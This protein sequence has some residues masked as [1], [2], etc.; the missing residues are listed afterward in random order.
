MAN[1][2]PAEITDQNGLERIS[3]TVTFTDTGNQPGGPWGEASTAQFSGSGDPTGVVTPS[4]EGDLY[5]DTSTPALYQATGATSSDWA[6]VGGSGFTGWTQDASNPANVSSNGGELDT[7]GGNVNTGGGTLIGGVV[8]GIPGSANPCFLADNT[9]GTAALD[10]AGLPVIHAAPIQIAAGVP[11]GA[12]T[13]L[14]F[15]FDS[16]AVTGGLYIWDGTVWVQVS[17]IP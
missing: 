7:N 6:I 13:S 12:P 10:C 15:A 5:V 11:S 9:F 16:T 14:P 1:P 2:Y 3:G 17:V 4:G 8:Q